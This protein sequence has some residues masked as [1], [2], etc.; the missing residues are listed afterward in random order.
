MDQ[1][2]IGFLEVAV[3]TAN[4]ALPVEGARV[5]V[6]NYTEGQNGNGRGSLIYSVLTDTDGKAPRL[7]LTAKSKALSMSPGSKSPYTAYTVNVEHEGYYSNQ[8]I[9]V[10]IFQGVTSLQPVELL[11]VT[12]YGNEDDDYPSP[13][14]RYV[15]IPNTRL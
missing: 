14:K 8:Y 7:S 10:P 11:P 6:Y 12:E 3:R 4:G 5:S 15:E 13:E 2:G 1:E 9:N